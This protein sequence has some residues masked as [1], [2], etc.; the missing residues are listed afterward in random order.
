MDKKNINAI[1]DGDRAFL[2]DTN[3]NFVGYGIRDEQTSSTHLYSDQGEY[4]GELVQNQWISPT[5]GNEGF[6]NIDNDP[7]ES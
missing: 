7:F 4:M 6:V 3:S 1:N 2:Y 5:M